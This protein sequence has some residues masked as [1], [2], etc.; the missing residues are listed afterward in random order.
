MKVGLCGYGPMGR[1]HAQLL[2]KHEDIQLVA[3]AEVQAD[4]RARAQTEL[5][6]QTFESGE[7]L[8]DARIADVVFVCAPTYLHA[9][10]TIRALRTGAHVFCEKPMG[11]NPRQCAAMIEASRRADRMLIIGQVLRFW[12]EYVFLKQAIDSG[13]YGRL[14]SLS[15]TRI[16]GVSIG[17]ERWFLDEQRGGMQI[18]DRHIYDTDLVIW[19]LGVPEAVQAFGFEKDARTDGGIVHSF[20]RYLYKDMAISAEGSADLPAKFPFT[21][22]YRAG[23]D[24]AA[25]EYSSRQT[26]TL[27][28]Y[29][30]NAEPETPELPQPLGTVQSGLNIA[31]ASGYF[32]EEVYFFDCIRKGRRP[33]IVTPE[34]AS[35]TIRVVRAEIRSV[36]RG[37][38]RIRIA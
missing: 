13:R 7:A 4:L 1:T 31:S 38:A 8:I 11:L 22:S 5:G 34:S 32:L 10:L 21:M 25:I 3:V 36:R 35:E 29:V 2:I 28:L 14:Q 24:N 33:Q 26:P 19:L 15:M 37:G 9:P 20:T 12:P 16:G 6:V 23:F 18:F 30:G 17:Y 27:K